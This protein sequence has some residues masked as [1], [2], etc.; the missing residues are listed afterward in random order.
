LTN[1]GILLNNGDFTF[2]LYTADAPGP[3]AIGDANNDGFVDVFNGTNLYLQEGNNGNN[4]LKIA[5]HGV[6][7]NINGIGARIEINSPG[8]GTQIR[9]VM[10]GTGFRYMS[11]LNTHFG[12]GSD[13]SVNSIT[14]YWP[15]GTVDVINNPGINTTIHV[16][17]GETLSLENSFIEDLIIYPNPV[18]NTL[19]IGSSLNLDQSIIS[20]F[21]IAGRRVMN[22]RL[23][24]GINSVN[25]SELSVGEYILRVIT[26]EGQMSSQKFIKH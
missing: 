9:D 12:I 14:V 13:S 20:V 22:Y 19:T 15:S 25:V 16:A 21:D 5:T 24:N 18:R 7:S 1:G 3:G 10:S 4:W 23:V 2:T 6:T 8:I 26:K 17:E 11:S